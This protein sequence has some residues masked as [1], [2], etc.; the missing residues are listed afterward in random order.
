RPKVTRG[1]TIEKTADGGS[2][3]IEEF[4]H[5]LLVIRPWVS[6]HPITLVKVK[7][8]VDFRDSLHSPREDSTLLCNNSPMTGIGSSFHGAGTGFELVASSDEAACSLSPDP[9]AWAD[10]NPKT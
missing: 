1:R 9:A 8:P 7:Q 10:S 3:R 6:S 5:N 4:P 2:I